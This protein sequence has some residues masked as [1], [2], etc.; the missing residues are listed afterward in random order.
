M[1][2]W[3]F[4]SRVQHFRDGRFSLGKPRRN[5]L[6]V[7]VLCQERAI[8]DL[9][10]VFDADRALPFTAVQ[11]SSVAFHDVE[12]M[13]ASGTA[14]GDPFRLTTERVLDRSFMSLRVYKELM[15]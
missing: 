5:D 7:C 6:M 3:Q 4:N 15:P 13:G 11:R 10:G 2:Q 9:L 1:L 14:G 8:S 12:V